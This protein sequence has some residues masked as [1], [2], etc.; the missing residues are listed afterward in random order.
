MLGIGY[1]V[2]A[3]SWTS[4][5]QLRGC[6]GGA[7]RRARQQPATFGPL[8]ADI[9]HWFVKRRGIAVAIV[10]S[11][12][13]LSGTIWPPILQPAIETIGWRDSFMGIGVFCVVTMVP[14][15]LL[16]RRK[17]PVDHG[18]PATNGAQ[19]RVA[20]MPAPPAVLQPRAGARRDR[21]L[22]RDVDAAGAYR[23]LLR[24]PR[25]RSGARRADAVADARLRH[26]QPAR[27]R[28]HRRPDRRRRHADPRLDPAM[29][30]A[31]AV[32]AVRR[33]DV[34]LCHLRPVR[35]VAGRHRA[36][37]CADRAPVFSRRARPA[38]ASG[39]C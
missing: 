6:P 27:L 36:E 7:D 35:P 31:A 19:L 12:N 32:P 38:G 14:I 16:M 9:S 18:A 2:A 15:A 21:L 24:R 25:L 28:L 10:A 5:W 11:G 1:V 20:R 17:A 37:L 13:Y 30:G 33:P 29:R 26:R 4:Y 34:A 3:H 22:R 23:R 8:V 39:W